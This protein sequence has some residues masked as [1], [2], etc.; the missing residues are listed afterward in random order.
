[1]SSG[2]GLDHLPFGICSVGD[3]PRRVVVRHG[4]RALDA[5]TLTGADEL[6]GPV[7]EPFLAA[8]PARWAEVRAQ[9]QAVLTDDAAAARVEAAATPLDAVMLHRPIAVGDFV[10]FYA[11]EQHAMNAGRIFRP[12]AEPLPVNWKHLPVGYHGRSGSVVVSGTDVVRPSGQRGAPDGPVFGPTRK[13][14]LEVEVGFVVGA[15]ST[16][17]VPV[18]V[19]AFAEHVFG[20]VLVNDWSARD[21][22][23]WETVPLGPFLGK[24]F[25]TSMSAWVTPLAAL[26]A[27]WVDPPA[28]DVPVLPYLVGDGD[29]EGGRGL[30]IDLELR[31]DGQLVSRPPFASMYWTPAQLLAH[32]TVNGASVRP[33]DLFASGTVSGARRDQWGSL[34]ELT[35]DGADPLT[36]DDDSVREYLQDGDVVTIGAT[37]PG[38]GGG[39]ITLGDVTGRV[40][41]AR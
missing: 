4:D 39:R 16:P 26:D 29:S 34:L 40:L 5:F 19:E 30:A 33:G 2:F 24:S 22:Q 15:G 8:G 20:V 36:R 32:L 1:M 17:G 31:I 12:G 28:R 10:D 27:A 37:A 11:S 9:L 23:R 3:G 14:D 35:W 41:P 25:A 7:L 18:G 13:L 6:A 21:I 38:V